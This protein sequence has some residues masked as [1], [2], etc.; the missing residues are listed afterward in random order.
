VRL[1]FPADIDNGS[2][3]VSVV[4][5]FELHTSPEDD[6]NVQYFVS[7]K[8]PSLT[9]KVFPVFLSRVPETDEPRFVVSIVMFPDVMYNGTPAVETT[10]VPFWFIVV[11]DTWVNDGVV[12]I[13]II[14]VVPPLEM[15]GVEPVTL[16]TVPDPPPDAGLFFHLLLDDSY[17]KTWA[18]VGDVSVTSVRLLKAPAEIWLST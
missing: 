1:K 12:D 3:A 6:E 2:E 9:D 10:F 5:P 17:V 14:G 11:A 18:S 4:P 16:V 13:E 15:I 8:V 7:V